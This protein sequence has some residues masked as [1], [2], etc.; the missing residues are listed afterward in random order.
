MNQTK[1]MSEEEDRPADPDGAEPVDFLSLVEDDLQAAGPDGEQA[2]AEV[3]EVAYFGVFDVG[4]IVDEAADHEDGQR[5]DGDVDVEGIAPAVGVGQPAAEGGAEDGR[6]D[7]AK[8]EEGHGA[9]RA[10]RGGKLSS[11][12]DWE[13][14]CSAPPPAP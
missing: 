14:G 11:R 7:D 5:A 12:M 13:S 6:D 3:V 10:W 2:E 9:R 1:A 4:R 8:G